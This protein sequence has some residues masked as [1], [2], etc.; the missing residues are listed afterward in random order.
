MYCRTPEI[1]HTDLTSPCVGCPADHP[2]PIPPQEPSLNSCSHGIMINYMKGH[3]EN[4]AKGKA[5]WRQVKW[6]PGTEQSPSP[7]GA[8]SDALNAS[9]PRWAQDVCIVYKS[10]LAT[11]SQSSVHAGASCK[12]FSAQD[13]SDSKP[14]CPHCIF[15]CLYERVAEGPWKAKSPDPKGQVS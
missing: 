6:N 3:R 1:L 12:A 11:Q 14:S 2:L 4:P 9:V 10:S 15:C 7:C 13:I 5:A 8:K